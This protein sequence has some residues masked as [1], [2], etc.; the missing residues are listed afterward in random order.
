MHFRHRVWL[1]QSVTVLR[2]G[3]ALTTERKPSPPA[4]AKEAPVPSPLLVR[5]VPAF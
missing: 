2:S 5:L 1:L 3:G 4:A